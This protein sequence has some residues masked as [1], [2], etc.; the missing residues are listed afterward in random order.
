[1]EASQILGKEKRASLNNS[2][3]SLA[4]HAVN[5]IVDGIRKVSRTKYL[6]QRNAWK[7]IGIV[8]NKAPTSEEGV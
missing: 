1:M 3:K 2:S 5:S 4:K 8:R 6:L 7:I